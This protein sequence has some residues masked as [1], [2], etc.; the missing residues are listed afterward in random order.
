MKLVHVFSFVGF[1]IYLLTSLRKM[2]FL[3]KIKYPML[4]CCLAEYGQ[5]AN[6]E[7]SHRSST[8]LKMSLIGSLTLYAS[9]VVLSYFVW[10]SF[11]LILPHVSNKWISKSRMSAGNCPVMRFCT[12]FVYLDFI[13]FCTN[14]I[15]DLCIKMYVWWSHRA[16]SYCVL[17]IKIWYCV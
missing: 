9:F 2:G 8:E 1:L 15:N 3:D 16:A 5:Y 10:S 14:T 6:S 17:A 7:I 12:A 4:T 13:V 11:S